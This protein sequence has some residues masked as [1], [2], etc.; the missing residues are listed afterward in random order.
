MYQGHWPTT[1]RK[2][3][4]ESGKA[5]ALS[6]HKITYPAF[7]S[8]T[9]KVPKR[10]LPV[11]SS[12]PIRQKKKPAVLSNP[13]PST[14]IPKLGHLFAFLFERLKVLSLTSVPRYDSRPGPRGSRTAASCQRQARRPNYTT[15]PAMVTEQSLG[16]SFHWITTGLLLSV[17]LLV[18]AGGCLGSRWAAPCCRLFL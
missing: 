1:C 8:A 4:E 15:G 11:A 10:F 5:L 17:L 2:L 14:A 7:D 6:L 12:N 9:W 3:C 16:S 18:L 13:S